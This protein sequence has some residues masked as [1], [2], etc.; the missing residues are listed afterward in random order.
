MSIAC[1]RVNEFGRAV[2]AMLMRYREAILERQYVHERI[3]DAACDLYASSCT[4]S[5]LDSLLI[6]GNHQPAEDK[7]DVIA[8]RYFLKLADRRIR[9]HL[10]A[11]HDNDDGET[12]RTA[13]DVL[14]E[15]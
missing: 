11:L 1:K 14:R 12:T 10:A 9:H 5:R 2:Q 6:G 8:G 7:A 4:L 3:A 15:F 13:N